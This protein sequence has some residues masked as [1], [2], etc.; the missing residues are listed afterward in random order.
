MP[1]LN[2]FRTRFNTFVLMV[3]AFLLGITPV[4]SSAINLAWISLFVFSVWILIDRW[5]DRRKIEPSAEVGQAL[6]VLMVAFS[7]GLALMIA[8]KLYWSE[9]VRGV[10]FELNAVVA[11]GIS[12]VFARFWAAEARHQT[13]VGVGVVM[14]SLL[15]LAQGYGYMFM[16]HSGPTNAVNWGAGMALFVSL[17]ISMVVGNRT[18]RSQ[19]FAVMGAFA[20]VLAIFVGGRRGAFFSIFWCAM[21]GG[22]AL[23]QSLVFNRQ[24]ARRLLALTAFLVVVLL[25]ALLAKDQLAVPLD[26]VMVAASEVKAMAGDESDRALALRSSVGSRFHMVELGLETGSTSPWV[27]VGAEGL[28]RVVQRAELDLQAP[29]FHLHN[30]YLQAWVAYGVF[31]LLATLC[32]PVGLLV[33]GFLLRHAAP[34]PALAMAGFGLAHFFSGLTNVNT[35]HNFYGT[36]FAV[37][38]ALPFL[39]FVPGSTGYR[40]KVS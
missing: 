36:V 22:Y 15:A 21:V 28:A 12:M 31:G 20:L 8:I 32:F 10:S 23:R 16:G 14:A 19:W 2:L 39:T 35:F 7:L 5:H 30:E 37:C 13:A 1:R 26:R 3:L 24:T 17:A 6:T 4:S 29:L 33:A 25:G 27:G 11:A 9:P 38:V 40:A 18:K 34:A